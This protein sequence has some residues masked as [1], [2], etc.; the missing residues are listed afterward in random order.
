ML[1][2]NLGTLSKERGRGEVLFSYTPPAPHSATARVTGLCRLGKEG[3]P[4]LAPLGALQQ[5]AALVEDPVVRSR[6]PSRRSPRVLRLVNA[7]D[8]LEELRI[9]QNEVLPLCK[10]LPQDCSE[11]HFVKHLL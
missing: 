9:D 7:I 1:A 6:R 10:R 8:V 4:I 11:I 3:W 5:V 2:N